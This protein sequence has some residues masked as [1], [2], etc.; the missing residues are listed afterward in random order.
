MVLGLN[1]QWINTY[2]CDQECKCMFSSP[3]TTQ[4]DITVLSWWWCSL[5]TMRQPECSGQHLEIEKIWWWKRA[6]PRGPPRGLRHRS[7]DVISDSCVGAEPGLNLSGSQEPAEALSRHP[8]A[9][10]VHFA[11]KPLKRILWVF[12]SVQWPP[13][14]WSADPMCFPGTEVITLW[15]CHGKRLIQMFEVL[16]GTLNVTAGHKPAY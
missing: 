9:S 4:S 8:P 6:I 3:R 16:Q 1:W 7:D 2:R 12:L 14:L 5:Q 13:T 15:P 10:H 11:T